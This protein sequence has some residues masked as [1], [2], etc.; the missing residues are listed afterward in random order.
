MTMKTMLAAA[1]ETETRMTVMLMVLWIITIWIPVL[2]TASIPQRT[3]D[4]PASCPMFRVNP[5]LGLTLWTT[6]TAAVAV[7]HSQQYRMNCRPQKQPMIEIEPVL[8]SPIDPFGPLD[9]T[10]RTNRI[11]GR[12]APIDRID[13]TDQLVTRRV[14]WVRQ[15]LSPQSTRRLRQHRL[16]QQLLELELELVQ[17]MLRTV[18]ATVWVVPVAGWPVGC[19]NSL[20]QHPVTIQAIIQATIQAIK[21]ATLVVTI[22][23]AKPAAT[24]VLTRMHRLLACEWSRVCKLIVFVM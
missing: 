14:C 3:L 4:S 15:Y 22:Q 12:N 1:A 24:R 8:P 13:P 19:P 7:S 11:T 18:E 5:R 17:E 2:S 23:A 20:L 21:E 10:S 6:I 16:R 9:L